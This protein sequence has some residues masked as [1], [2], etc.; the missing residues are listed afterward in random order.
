MPF[1]V[2][3]KDKPGVGAELDKLVEEHWSYMDRFDE[4]LILR[5][6]TLSDDGEEH[7]GSV[8]IVDLDDRAAADRFG[9][10]EPF[11]QA[12]LYEDITTERAAVLLDRE[13]SA[14]SRSGEA[15]NALLVGRWE[16][17]PHNAPT[18]GADTDAR[19]DFVALLVDDDQSHTI[20]FVAVV[21][22]MPDEAEAIAR[23]LADRFAGEA[24]PLAV[25]RWCRGG[26]R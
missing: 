18:L 10:E 7:T 21:T 19:L 5:G 8:H 16:P 26:R 3:A 12:G 4:R 20:G 15:P 23:P 13:P 24:V 17:K 25:T 22:A 11:W 9:D 1:Y 2:H 14:A 6:P